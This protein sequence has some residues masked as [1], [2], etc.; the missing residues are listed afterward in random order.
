MELKKRKGFNSI[1]AVL[2]G[3]LVIMALGLAFLPIITN[4]TTGLQDTTDKIECGAQSD[5]GSNIPG[6]SGD[7]CDTRNSDSPMGEDP[8]D[9]SPGS[10][11]GD[12]EITQAH[13]LTGTNNNLR[14]T[15][16]AK[17]TSDQVQQINISVGKLLRD[18]DDGWIEQNSTQCPPNSCTVT[19][20]PITKKKDM[21]IGVF[22]GK[23]KDPIANG[24]EKSELNAHVVKTLFWEDDEWKVKK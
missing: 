10:G 19:T 1:W 14:V 6:I 22:L 11:G 7:N 18:G 20:D 8:G 21:K 9:G 12:V 4:A 2:I 24:L 23:K 15:A 3:A 5:F 13:I 17:N 16:S